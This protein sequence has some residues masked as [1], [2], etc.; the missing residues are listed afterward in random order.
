[1]K[2]QTALGPL[3]L[4]DLKEKYWGKKSVV[5]VAKHGNPL[6]GLLSLE[7]V[8][9]RLNDGC[10]TL[11]NL[12][13]IAQTGNKLPHDALYHRQAGPSWAPEFLK[14]SALHQ[15]LAQ[16]HSF[17]MHNMTHITPRVAELVADIE[18]HF[19]D[20]AA[21]VHLYVSPRKGA[22]G[23]RAHKDEPQHKIY[24][25]IVGSTSWRVFSGTHAKKALTEEETREHLKVNFEATLTPGSVL[26]M[27]PGVFHQ[28]SNPE[29]PRLSVSIPIAPRN[30][31]VVPV[32]R[33]HVPLAQLM[34][35]S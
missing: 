35:S 26:Y 9:T 28:A 18:S 23:Y 5:L 20:F 33:H 12:S 21:D 13:V 29:G 4:Q 14:K 7:E 2:L 10:A 19:P 3:L 6:A 24:L 16:D 31:G 15:L 22:T 17:V 34:R 25:Q 1:M 27:P 11:T 30:A 32:D 8:E